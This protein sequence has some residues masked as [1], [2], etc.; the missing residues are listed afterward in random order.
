LAELT[1]LGAAPASSPLLGFLVA[2][3][4]LLAAGLALLTLRR[5][6]RPLF[7]S[8]S[9]TRR[10][11]AWALV[12]GLCSACFA[13]VIAPALL[14]RENSPWLLA[15]GDVM[16]VTLALFVWVMV[17]SEGHTLRDYGFRIGPPA[18][19]AFWTLV[20]I[21]PLGYF[22]APA[23]TALLNGHAH[24]TPDTLVFAAVFA[25]LGTA[26]PEE[27]LFRG[28]LM[29]SFGT[30]GQRWVR[31]VVPALAFTLVR[32]VRIVPGAELA[33]AAWM[34]YI[35]GR[36]LPLGVWWGLM[37]DLS[38]GSLWPGLISHAALEFV[39]VLAI[40]AGAAH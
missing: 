3:F 13:R 7:G 24:V 8:D 33:P 19:L 22:L 39:T 4:V 16:S 40:T 1:P 38:G 12:Y 17:I 11:I 10:A 32:A 20:A 9:S 25:V 28:Y 30:R 36:V 23:V 5:Q 37:R 21:A 29:G 18:L 27:I 34:L 35:F 2:G 26:L 31:L 6:R 14:G 15:L